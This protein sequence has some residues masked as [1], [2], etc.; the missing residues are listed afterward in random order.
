MATGLLGRAG[1]GYRTAGS[2]RETSEDWV[3]VQQ[4]GDLAIVSPACGAF[5]GRSNYEEKLESV[6]DIDMVRRV[7]FVSLSETTAEQTF[8]RL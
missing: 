7:F 1:P 3:W 5:A 2:S 6:A 8:Y 4:T